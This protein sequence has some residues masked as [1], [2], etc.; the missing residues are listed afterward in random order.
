MGVSQAYL[1]K[2]HLMEKDPFSHIHNSDDGH[3]H[4]GTEHKAFSPSLYYISL[5]VINISP[6]SKGIV[7]AVVVLICTRNLANRQ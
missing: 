4:Q 5:Y 1:E 2:D 6:V 7:V 3:D